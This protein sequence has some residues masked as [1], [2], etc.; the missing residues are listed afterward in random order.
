MK[1]KAVFLDRDGVINQYPGDYQYVK[2][3]EEFR[4]LPGVQSA[5]KNLVDN[6]FKIFIISNQ[7]GVSKGIYSQENLDKITQNMLNDFSKHGIEVSGVY[8]CIHRQ[9]DNCSCRKPKIGLIEMALESLKN[10]SYDIDLSR[11]FFIGDT[12][13]DIETGK[14]SGLKTILVFSGKEKPE[15]KKNWPVLPDFT[16][17]NLEKAVD[18]IL[19]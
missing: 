8:Y 3:W 12:I 11:S 10:K 7:A 13:K 16:S 6:G 15:N 17:P 1:V 2:S 5:L 14:S 18:L 9:E 19:K 4:F